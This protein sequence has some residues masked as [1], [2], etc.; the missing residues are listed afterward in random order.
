MCHCY[1]FCTSKPFFIASCNV[2][3]VNLDV[4]MMVVHTVGVHHNTVLVLR[5]LIQLSL[6]HLYACAY[7]V[8]TISIAGTY[9]RRKRGGEGATRPPNFTHCLHN[10]LYCSIVDHI[11]CRH[12][13][14][15]KSHFCCFKKM[16]PPKSEHLPTLM[17]N[18]CLSYSIGWMLYWW[19]KLSLKPDV[20][21]RH[22]A[23]L[24]VG[25][26]FDSILWYYSY[27]TKYGSFS[28]FCHSIL[29]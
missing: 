29:C 3:V 19:Q 13:S 26:N 23:L 24:I 10:E 22:N 8:G 5:T 18:S 2:F 21:L 25:I 9:R 20:H 27:R 7:Q 15:R 16:S 14:S 17:W 12:C 4:L 1:K 6:Q 28:V 11:A